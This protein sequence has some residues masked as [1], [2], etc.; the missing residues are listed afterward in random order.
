MYIQPQKTGKIEVINGQ[1][2]QLVIT[3]QKI[4]KRFLALALQIK[5]DYSFIK[6]KELPILLIEN[7]MGG[8][9]TAKDLA[10]TLSIVKM[11]YHMDSIDFKRFRKNEN[12]HPEPRI[13]KNPNAETLKNRHILIVEDVLDEGITLKFAIKFFKIWQPA[14]IKIFVLGWKKEISP[15]FQPDYY[16]FILPNQWLIGEGMDD[17]QTERGR[18]GIWQKI[19]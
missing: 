5:K 18:L 15:N 12:G 7:L 13:Y 9:F 11:P 17:N 19:K 4:E 14:S 2:Y 8:S 3:R 6:T 1:K 16:G 10:R